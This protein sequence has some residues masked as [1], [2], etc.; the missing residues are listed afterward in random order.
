MKEFEEFVEKGTVIK[1]SVNKSRAK[2]LVEESGR[3]NK[4]LKLILEKIGL[5]ND[6][7]NDIVEF[8]YDI[9]MNLLRAILY[10]D[11]LKAS[12]EGSHEAEVS[13]SKEIGFSETEAKFLNDLRYY[14]NGI[15]YYGKRFDADY[16][17]SVLKFLEKVIPRMK[18][19]LSLP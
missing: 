15:K 1:V 12:G 11:G 2:A 4:N 9:I 16:A 17:A 10:L 18:K 6:N 3:R 19:R 13:Y 14:R 8:C 5:T 7:A